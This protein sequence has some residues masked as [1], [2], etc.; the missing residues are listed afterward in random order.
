MY[1]LRF[2][3]AYSVLAVMP[4]SVRAPETCTVGRRWRARWRHGAWRLAGAAHGHPSWF[5]SAGW[6]RS[7]LPP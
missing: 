2:A 6:P 4:G 1:P 3:Y 7:R 5:R